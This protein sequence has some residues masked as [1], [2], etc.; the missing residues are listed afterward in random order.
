MD[1]DPPDPGG[2]KAYRTDPAD[3]APDPQHCSLLPR[4]NGTMLL[5]K[6]IKMRTQNWAYLEICTIEKYIFHL[7]VLQEVSIIGYVAPGKWTSVPF[8]MKNPWGFSTV[9]QGKIKRICAK[10]RNQFDN[11]IFVFR[12][13]NIL[14]KCLFHS[15][16]IY[17]LAQL[18]L[19]S[20]QACCAV[21]LKI[22]AN[23]CFS[24]SLPVKGL[25]S[26]CLP[27]VATVAEAQVPGE[28]SPPH[29]HRDVRVTRSYHRSIPHLQIF[30]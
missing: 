18:N 23:V 13:H 10:R 21:I 3:P 24:T 17:Y 27:M 2:P 1:Q 20:R 26:V 8:T 14:Q 7:R 11:S 25:Y 9:L 6:M 22:Q 16:V 15:Y 5:K 4:K 19:R 30:V 12:L 28:G 29:H